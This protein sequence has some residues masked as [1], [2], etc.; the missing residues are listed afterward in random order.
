LN[1]NAVTRH[2]SHDFIAPVK[3]TF[4]GVFVSCTPTLFHFSSVFG[5]LLFHRASEIV[6]P[7]NGVLTW[8][9][10]NDEDEIVYSFLSKQ[11]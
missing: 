11:G 6:S 2:V 9:P 1:P 3:S 5:S 10:Q 4:T 7:K 8:N